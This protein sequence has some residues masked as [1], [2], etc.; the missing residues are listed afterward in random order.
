MQ[1]S[2]MTLWSERKRMQSTTYNQGAHNTKCSDCGVIKWKQV[3]CDYPI[4]ECQ[5]CGNR[6]FSD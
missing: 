6:L 5:D 1:Y 3:P 4:F 2:L